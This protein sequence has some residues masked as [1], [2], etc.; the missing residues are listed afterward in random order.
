VL[1]TFVRVSP[2]LNLHVGGKII[3]TTAEHPFY[4]LDFG[5]KPA[6][7]LKTGDRLKGLAEE[8]L[9]VDGI[10]DSGR[11]ETVYNLEVEGDH[12]YFV[13]VAGQGAAVWAHNAGYRQRSGMPQHGSV[14]HHNRMVRE[15]KSTDILPTGV[16]LAKNRG[17]MRANQALMNPANPNGPALSRL[18][19]DVQ[20][21]GSDG[22]IYIKEVNRTGGKDYHENREKQLR[23]VLGSSFGGYKGINIR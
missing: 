5:W 2:I 18:R 17:H 8:I 19:P 20:I 10:A 6:A 14:P 4:V 21:R 3:G 22:K 1:Q 15:C 9:I 13:G 16:K 12:T 23:E 7:E 11:V